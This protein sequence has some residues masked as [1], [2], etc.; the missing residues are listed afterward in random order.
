[1]VNCQIWAIILCTYPSGCNLV[2]TFK[3]VGLCL[4]MRSMSMDRQPWVAMCMI[5]FIVK[6]CVNVCNMQLEDKCSM[7]DVVKIKQGVGM[8]FHIQTSK[9]SWQMILKPIRM[10]CKL[11]TVLV[12]QVRF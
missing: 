3:H 1:M 11:S 6:W 10:P 12:T 2:V 5:W 4:I 8:V 7:C 9:G